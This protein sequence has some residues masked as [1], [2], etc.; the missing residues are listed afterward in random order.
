[1]TQANE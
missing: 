1:L